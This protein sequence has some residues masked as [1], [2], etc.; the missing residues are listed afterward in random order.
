MDGQ[1][2]QS[3]LQKIRDIKELLTV[4]EDKIENTETTVSEKTGVEIVYDFDVEDLFSDVDSALNILEDLR[5]EIHYE[6]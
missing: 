2:L 3:W 6:E 5:N 4:V 1:I